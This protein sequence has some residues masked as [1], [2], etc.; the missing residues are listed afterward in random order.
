MSP[1]PICQTSN[2]GSH[3]CT[4][5][6]PAIASMP[7]TIT[8]KYQYIQPLMNP[9]PVAERDA[10]VFGERAEARLIERH[11]RQDLDDHEHDDAGEDVAQHHGRTDGGDRRAAA[12]EHPGADDAA[13]GDHRQVAGAQGLGEFRGS[14]QGNVGGVQRLFAL[15]VS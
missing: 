4:I 15:V 9:A 6:A 13:D 5:F 8:Q 1:R 2:I 10:H 14:G 3:P 7:T 11:A 12:D